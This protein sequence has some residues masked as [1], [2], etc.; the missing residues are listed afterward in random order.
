MTGL[1]FE[2]FPPK[3]E[4]AEAKLWSA[5]KRLAPLEPDFVSVTY[6]AGGSTRD[7]THACLRKI[8]QETTLTPAAHLTCVAA[9]REDVD[10]V[11]ADYQATGIRHIVALRGD[12]PDM[13][14]FEAHADGYSGSVELIASI[15]ARG[16]FEIS[17]SAYPE[18]HPESSSFQQD[19]ELLKAKIDAGASRAITQFAF[20]TQAFLRYRDALIKANIEIPILPGIMPTTNFTGARRMASLC[21]AAVPDALI[22]KYEGLEDDLAHTE[23]SRVGVTKI[24]PR[25]S[26]TRPHRIALR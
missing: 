7:R 8:V 1:S 4:A 10:S 16:G 24:H 25:H 22:A 26:S 3:T 11:I 12:M 21:G 18:K 14:A 9:S 23:I 2:F 17:V 19:I 20:D 5:V 15:A 6:G 13:G